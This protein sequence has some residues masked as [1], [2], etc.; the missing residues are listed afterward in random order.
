MA[1]YGKRCEEDIQCQAVLGP[2]S[3][4]NHS[5]V[6]GMGVCNCYSE[7]EFAIY[8]NGRCNIPREIGENCEND[9]DCI[10]GSN[11]GSNVLAKCEDSLCICSRN[12]A[13]ALETHLN[14]D[15]VC[16]MECKDCTKVEISLMAIMLSISSL[17]VLFLYGMCKIMSKQD[18]A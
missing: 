9:N 11:N 16:V 15:G 10:L 7:N 13:L 12:P 8:F 5:L 6:A 1:S 2:H 4:C 18:H 3:T 17:M 14:S